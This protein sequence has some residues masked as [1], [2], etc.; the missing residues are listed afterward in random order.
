MPD[1]TLPD[2]LPTTETAAN[3]IIRALQENDT[4]CIF[5][6]PGGAVTPLLFAADDNGL[7]VVVT[8]HETGAAFVAMG[9]AQV[10]RRLGVCAVTAGP[11]AT[12]AITGIA[13]AMHDSAPVVLLT[14]Q[15]AT[16]AYGRGAFQDSSPIG[17]LDIT[18]LY[19][20]VTKR[21]V[22]LPDAGRAHDIAQHLIREALSARQGPVQ[23]SVP[24]NLAV[25]RVPTATSPA[26]AIREARPS[27][28]GAIM[29]TIARELTAARCPAILAG[30]GVYVADA[31]EALRAVAERFEV[32]VATT[33]KGKGVFPEEHPLS[34]GVFGFGGPT[35]AESYL[36]D[37]KVDLLVVV[38]TSL[39]EFQT[40]G[41]HSGLG[42][43][44]T[45]VQIDIDP[46][47][48]GRTYRA[49]IAVNAD[50]RAA[51]ETLVAV[52][53]TGLEPPE[54][55]WAQ[56]P[57]AVIAQAPPAGDGLSPK[58]AVGAVCELLPGDALFFVDIGN[59]MGLASDCHR[60]RQTGTYFVGLG[61]GSM[62]YAGPA[63]IGAKLAR[64][65]R[66]VV[67]LMGD[68]AFAMTGMEIHTAVDNDVPVVW[69]VLNNSGHGMVHTGELAVFGDSKPW[70]LFGRPLDIATVA[71]GLGASVHTAETIEDVRAAMCDGLAAGVPTVIDVRVD[72]DETP[73]LVMQRSEDMR[74][75][76][77]VSG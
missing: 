66:P 22:L 69:V 60:V 65:D 4:E 26:R 9:Y 49:E 72:A 15:V 19:E 18:G 37:E 10:G 47:V 3:A 20:H 21:S 63:S 27:V 11:G 8:R 12:N 14:G 36:L 59:C 41:Y 76:I 38:G 77:T 46:A 29:R 56:R 53:A 74:A 43:D 40:R 39:G 13:A 58:E 30:H 50:A 44:R 31:C 73:A 2:D 61:L 57:A 70:N 5:A 23:L 34:L 17:P 33:P 16:S 6:I 67:A 55:F 45:V 64:P 62:G 71:A 48:I 52:G 24:T 35:P 75:R 7:R 32:P 51:L 68:G 28:D 42:A 1:R 25:S 54:R